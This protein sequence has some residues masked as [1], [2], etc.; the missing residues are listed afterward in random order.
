MEE[1]GAVQRADHMVWQDGLEALPHHHLELE[2]FYSVRDKMKEGNKGTWYKEKQWFLTGRGI[3]CEAAMSGNTVS[4]Q[5][6][7]VLLQV[8]V[9]Q[10]SSPVFTVTVSP[11]K[12]T[13]RDLCDGM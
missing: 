1:I 10:D 8:W 4:L 13:C 11:L 6:A 7:S 2:G 3:R 12:G 5:V 9:L